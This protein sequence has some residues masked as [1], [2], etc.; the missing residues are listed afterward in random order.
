MMEEYPPMFRYW[1]A[2][3]LRKSFG[4]GHSG[5]GVMLNTTFLF[6]DLGAQRNHFLSLLGV[7]HDL[8][9]V[10]VKGAKGGGEELIIDCPLLP[11]S[12]Q[13]EKL[14]EAV[15]VDELHDAYIEEAV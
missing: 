13:A 3:P 2:Q 14:C 11:I 1:K 5:F 6:L 7:A 15:M 12:E 10:E 9:E 4:S 8:S